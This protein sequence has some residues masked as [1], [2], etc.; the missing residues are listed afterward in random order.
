MQAHAYKTNL[1][2]F[3]VLPIQM[4]DSIRV[5]NTFY[6]LHE[7]ELECVRLSTHKI[8]PIFKSILMHSF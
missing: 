6:S 1:I 7:S 2:W 4:P 3:S 8:E 5:F